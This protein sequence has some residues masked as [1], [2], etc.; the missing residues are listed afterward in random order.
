MATLTNFDVP[1]LAT[2]ALQG[3]VNTLVPLNA[4]SRSYTSESVETNTQV[5]VPVIASVTATTFNG[6]YSVSGGTAT[7]ITVQINKHKIAPV[8][9]RDIDR[10]ASSGAVNAESWMYQQG[11]GLG[12][13]ILQDIWSVLTTANFAIATTV[14]STSIGVAE[15]RK[16]RK[17]LVQ[18]KVQAMAP[19]AYVFDN[20]P[21][22]T[23]LGISQYAGNLF[24]YNN[25][26]LA[27]GQIPRVLGADIYETNSLPG[28]SISLMGF[29]A[30]PQAIGVAMRYLAPQDGNTYNYAAPV[31]DPETGLTMGVRDYYDNSAGIRYMVLECQYGY[32]AG[33]TNA[34][35]L[36]TRTD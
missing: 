19:R 10:A 12:Y 30:N 25:S 33:L 11:M 31:T 35:R 24:A 6:S 17:L 20:D 18:N 23:L 16:G 14:A 34:C 2:A 3:L 22:D 27:E 21:Y 32:A 13:L 4:F 1:R 26:A 36:Y 9:F 8:S 29:I 28:N 5:L 7:V 15:L